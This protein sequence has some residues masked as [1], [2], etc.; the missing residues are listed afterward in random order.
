MK[1][2]S[3]EEKIGLYRAMTRARKFGTLSLKQYNAGTMGGF[4]LMSAGQEGAAIVARFLMR[5]GDQLICGPRSAAHAIAAGMSMNEMMAELYGRSTGSSKGKGG[6]FGFF[7][8]EK[9]FHGGYAA[10]G[11]QT[12]VATGL[13]FALKYRDQRN[14]AVSFLGDGATN[15]GPFHESLNLASLFRLP[16]VFIIENNEFSMGTSLQRHSAIRDSLAQRAEGYDMAWDVVEDGSDLPSM[17]TQ[18]EVAFDRA[19]HEQRPTLLEVRTSRFYGFTVSDAMAKKYRTPEEI[20]FHKVHHDPIENWGKQLD[21][22]GVLN[23][24]ARALIDKA[25]LDE[26]NAAA[27]FADKAPLPDLSCLIE[28]VYWELDHTPRTSQGTLIFE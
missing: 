16:V 3:S 26:A 27:A 25:A 19:R 23:P 1:E 22:E 11:A 14:I 2:L 8:P 6:T 15:Q 7:A 9:G 4:L 13:A 18:F 21:E 10:A 17:L 24:A 28:D 20:Q 5:G 12:P